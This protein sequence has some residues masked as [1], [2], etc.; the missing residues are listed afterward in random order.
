MISSSLPRLPILRFESCKTGKLFDLC[1][2][3]MNIDSF[4]LFFKP[5]SFVNIIQAD[6]DLRIP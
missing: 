6:F 4:F 2:P 3:E 5:H 1:E